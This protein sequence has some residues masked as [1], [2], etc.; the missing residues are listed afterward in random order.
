[1][2]RAAFLILQNTKTFKLLLEA[3]SLVTSF[4]V[5]IFDDLHPAGRGW[6][7]DDAFVIACVCVVV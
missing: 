6:R 7:H 4:D 2:D 1:M 5:I 3:L